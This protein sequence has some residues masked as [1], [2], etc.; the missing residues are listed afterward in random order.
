MWVWSLD[1]EDPVEEEMATHSSIPNWRIPWTEE[2]GGQQPI[3]PQR[4][5]HNW[6]IEHAYTRTW[7]GPNLGRFKTLLTQFFYLW[8]EVKVAHLCP[9]LCNPLSCSLPGSSVK[10]FSRQEYWSG[11]PFPSPGGSSW[12]RDQT[13]VSCIGRRILYPWATR[14]S[15]K[16]GQSKLEQFILISQQNN[17]INVTALQ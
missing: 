9:T 1:W 3:R 13:R 10:E 8:S 17:S 12:P 11:L 15:L 14:E 6:A 4:V 2:P 16:I 7:E 5:G